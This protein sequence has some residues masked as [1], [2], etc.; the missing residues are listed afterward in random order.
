MGTRPDSAP[1]T[2][3]HSFIP[4]PNSLHQECRYTQICGLQRSSTYL[5][6]L[7]EEFHV[8]IEISRLSTSA[9]REVSVSPFRIRN[10]HLITFFVAE[11]CARD[12]CRCLFCFQLENGQEDCPRRRVPC[13]HARGDERR[14]YRNVAEV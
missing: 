9:S 2:T 7:K 13:R 14:C 6:N 4:W 1:A 12:Q 10:Y 3:T 5:N 11:G 8:L